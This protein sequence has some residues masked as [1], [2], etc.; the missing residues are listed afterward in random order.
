MLPPKSEKTHKKKPH[1]VNQH[2]QQIL[3]KERKKKQTFLQS[4]SPTGLHCFSWWVSLPQRKGRN[5]QDPGGVYTLLPPHGGRLESQLFLHP[6]AA[7]TRPVCLM[8]QIR[9]CPVSAH[10]HQSSGT[11]CPVPAHSIASSVLPRTWRICWTHILARASIAQGTEKT[12]CFSWP[13]PLS[14]YPYCKTLVI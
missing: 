7:S 9:L 4:L 14:L 11:V 2:H 12:L 13:I 1:L 3:K 8:C 5:I 10:F 6:T